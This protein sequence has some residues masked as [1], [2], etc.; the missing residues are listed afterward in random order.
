MKKHVQYLSIV[1]GLFMIMNAQAQEIP[2]TL[3]TAYGEGADSYVTNDDK[4]GPEESFGTGTYLIVRNHEV[5]QR[6]IYLKFDI[7]NISRFQNGAN[8]A[9]IGLYI[10]Y[11]EKMD[12]ALTS[13]D[14][15][16]YGMTD[17]DDDDWIDSLL[18][19]NNA[20]GTLPADLNTYVLDASNIEYLTSINVIGDYVGWVFSEP[21]QA[22]DD[23]IN[24]SNTNNLLTFI[25]LVEETN[26]GDE[27]RIYTEEDTE[28]NRPPILHGG[29]PL[30]SIESISHSSFTLE[31]NFPNPFKGNTTLTYTL[32]EPQ[33][34]ELTMYNM[35]GEKVVTLVNE[36]QI[37]GEYNIEVDMNKLQMSP[38]IYYTRINVGSESQI[39]KM[40]SYK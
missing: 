37:S 1:V 29:E 13:V 3:S 19:Y 36:F 17:N 16:V 7:E 24:V 9:F 4:N 2:D 23:F 31:Q 32:N 11:A 14:I 22:M 15:S 35:I 21:T 30:N 39:I 18:T 38:G 33:Q 34:V 20:P 25:L 6:I 12:E 8:Q 28:F 26:A 40:I 10:K 27:I 5:R